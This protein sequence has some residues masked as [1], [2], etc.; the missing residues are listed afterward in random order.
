MEG[1]TKQ[2]DLSNRFF[3][4]IAILVL[5]V[6]VFFVGQMAYQFQSLDRQNINQVTVSGQGKV[7]VKPD[8]AMVNLGVTTTGVTTADVIKRNTEKM[9]AVIQ[10]VKDSGVEEKD[11]QTTNY[12]LSPLYNYTEAAGRIFQGY[13]L[14][15]NL[16]VKIRDFAKV[17]DILQ[18]A[19]SKGANLTSN[20]Q[21][22]IENPEQFKQEARAKAIEQAKANATDLVKASGIELGKIVNIYENYNYPMYDSYKALG[23]GGAS[24]ESIPS[25]VIQPGQTEIDITVNLTYRIK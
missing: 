20:L 7:Y 11:I 3:I 21:F 6:L 15:Q 14:E 10:A 17:G 8:I 1:E 16:Q 9:N 18:Q 13:T 4:I 19:V 23:M 5:G 24:S 12:S 2:F 25:P 22:T